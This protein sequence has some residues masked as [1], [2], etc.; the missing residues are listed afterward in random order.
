M[1]ES[2]GDSPENEHRSRAR[3]PS[4]ACSTS[5][6]ETKIPCATAHNGKD[7]ISRMNLLLYQKQTSRTT[8]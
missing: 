6:V 8:C 4:T 3:C 1:R 7:Y 5:A 2:D